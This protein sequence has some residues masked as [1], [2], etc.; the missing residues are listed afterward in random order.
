MNSQ[1]CAPPTAGPPLGIAKRRLLVV[2][3]A[4]LLLAAVY[5]FVNHHLHNE[6]RLQNLQSELQA[7]NVEL[8][9]VHH[10][11]RGGKID[12]TS[13]SATNKSQATP[14]QLAKLQSDI[15]QTTSELHRLRLGIESMRVDGAAT[16]LRA[17]ERI[18]YALASIGGSVVHTGNSRLYRNTLQ[19][20]LRMLSATVAA[21]FATSGALAPLAT[22]R[23]APL[24]II[25]PTA[26]IGECFGFYGT[27]GEVVLRLQRRIFVEAV[28]IDHIRGDMAPRGNVNSAPKRFSV[29]GLDEQAGAQHFFGSFEYRIGETAAATSTLQMFEIPEALRQPSVSFELVNFRFQSNHGN[30]EYTCVY[31]VKV[32]GKPDEMGVSRDG[33]VK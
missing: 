14:T 4:G 21:A 18:D 22:G 17:A 8:A 27:V 12:P 13:I 33:L 5:M 16:M 10:C 32:H 24:H 19:R 30:A 31:Q 6:R 26:A 2:L 11:H 15:V 3:L 1:Y 28:S 9:H 20:L 29:Y 7:I 23:N 25:H